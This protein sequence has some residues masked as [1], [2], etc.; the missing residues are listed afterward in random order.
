MHGYTSRRRHGFDPPLY[1][2]QIVTWIIFPLLLVDYYCILMFFLWDMP[3]ANAILTAIYTISSLAAAIFVYITCII[4]PADDALFTS[5]ADLPADSIY[6]YLCECRVQNSSKHCR[7]CDKC[8]LKFDHHCKWLNTCIGQKNYRYFL[9]ILLS[10]SIMTTLS[11]GLSIGFLIESIAYPTTFSKKFQNFDDHRES[12]VDLLVARVVLGV[13]IALLLPLVLMVLQLALFH[14][15]LIYKGLTTY[16]FIVQ[17]QKRV[18]EKSTGTANQPRRAQSSSNLSLHQISAGQF[19]TSNQNMTNNNNNYSSGSSNPRGMQSSNSMEDVTSIHEFNAQ[20]S[21]ASLQPSSSSSELVPPTHNQTPVI[22][23]NN[24]MGNNSA[25]NSNNNNNNNSTSKVASPSSMMTKSGNSAKFSSLSIGDNPPSSPSTQLYSTCPPPTTSPPPMLAAVARMSSRSSKNFSRNECMDAMNVQSLTSRSVNSLSQSNVN[26]TS[27][28]TNQ[29]YTDLNQCE[30]P[31]M[32]RTSSN[33]NNQRVH[34]SN[35]ISIRYV[36]SD[37]EVPSNS[38]NNYRYHAPNTKNDD[39]NNG[40]LQ[41]V[42]K[43]DVSI[44]DISDI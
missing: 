16:D 27:N 33:D 24:Y 28:A 13:A 25:S 37:E 29:G 21:S 12:A 15:F 36:S 43:G 1:K 32:S 8:V 26:S 44:E 23:H 6:C 11:L 20:S 3:V 5:H 22:S 31:N 18:R 42:V 35:S 41:M 10:V 40:D 9:G 34:S 7:Y 30:S 38:N 19:N 39:P 17:E 14:V 2:L 4:D